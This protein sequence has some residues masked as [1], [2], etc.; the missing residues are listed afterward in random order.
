MFGISCAPELFQ[1]VM[2]TIVA[3]L[4]GVVV[5]LDDILI[6]GSSQKEHDD[7]LEALMNRLKEYGVLLNLDKCLFNVGK[8]DFLGHELSPEGI[9]PMKN[10]V[11]AIQQF[12]E[13]ANAAELRSFLGLVTYVGRFIPHLAT[14]TDPLCF[15]LRAG[16]NFSWT[17]KQKQAFEDIKQAICEIS[18]LGY[19][20]TQDKTILI[21]DA[22]PSGLGTVLLQENSTGLR[23]IIAYASKTLTDLERKYS[24]TEKEALA[25]VWAVDRFKLY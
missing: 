14:K 17:D 22:S 5:Y 12:R 25:L 4:E 2:D 3:G 21:A 7:R 1:K 19:F 16:N 10:R 20:N 15:L 11:L 8:L 13:P 23:R 18:H 9:K 6:F 24:Q